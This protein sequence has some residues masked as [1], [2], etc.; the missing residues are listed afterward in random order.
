MNEKSQR[1]DFMDIVKGIL[2]IFVVLGHVLIVLNPNYDRMIFTAAQSFIYSFHMAAF[3]MIHGI[4]F[5]NEK[6]KEISA[7]EFI[8]KRFSTTIVPYIFFEVIGM[9]CRMLIYKQ[10]LTAGVYNMLTI[11]CNIGADWFL[12]ALFMGSLLHFIYC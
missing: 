4:L 3:F 2:M 9:L 11:R 7:K 5:N 1:I 6:Y 12:P 10:P 8:L